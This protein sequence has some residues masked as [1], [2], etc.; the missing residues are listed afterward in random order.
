MKIICF[1][2]NGTLVEESPWDSFNLDVK[3]KEEFK[4]VFKDFYENKI[5]VADLWEKIVLILKENK[6]DNEEYILESFN[7][8]MHLKEGAEELIK[9]LK[10]KEYKICLIS[11]S[12]DFYLEKLCK[13][14]LI[15]GFY[16]GTH[17]YFKNKKLDIIQ[18][19][20]VRNNFKE[21]K[22]KE[23]AEKEK[24]NL[25]EIIFVGDGKNDVGVFKLTGKGIAIDSN[26]EELNNASWRK[27]KKLE[28]IK[29]I[30]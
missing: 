26:V 3:S 21:R 2:V 11:C 7:P 30:L 24:A 6:K 19:E 29:S 15:D 18:S 8:K 28:E 25:N 14:L 16:A 4:K 22:I 12:V 20:C 10:Q 27:I 23:L 17:F 5:E 13:L 1:D 9:Y